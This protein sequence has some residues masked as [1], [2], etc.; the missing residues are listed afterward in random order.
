MLATR[1][2]SRVRAVLGV[3]IGVRDLF[4]APTVVALASVVGRGQGGRRPVPRAGRRSGRVPLSFAQGRLWF[5]NR[6]DG[7]AAS[8]NLPVAV[9][10]TGQV[11]LGV[12][13]AAVVDLIGRHE[14]LRTVFPECDGVPGGAG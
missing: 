3:E 7:A 10:L 13:R 14:S 2:V 9:R 4:V 8:Y 6:L 5:L 11:D 1:L 12:L